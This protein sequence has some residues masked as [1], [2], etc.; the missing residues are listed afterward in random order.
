[1]ESKASR[2]DDHS[3]HKSGGHSD[4]HHDSQS[5]SSYMA[6]SKDVVVS[7]LTSASS[8]ARGDSSDAKARD[9]ELEQDMEADEEFER[10]KAA[11]V[12]VVPAVASTQVAK[13][14]VNGFKM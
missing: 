7:K 2:H 14:F 6:E 5:K 12:V 1:M 4:H 9:L 11:P 3:S 13:N 10:M 8:R